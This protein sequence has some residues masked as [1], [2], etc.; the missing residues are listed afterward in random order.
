MLADA[1]ERRIALRQRRGYVE[2]EALQRNLSR[3]A[4]T[5]G[6]TDQ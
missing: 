4:G 3:E 2:E 6:A 1:F 5:D